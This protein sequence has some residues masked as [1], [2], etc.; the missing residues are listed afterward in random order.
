MF[1]ASVLD[2]KGLVSNPALMSFLHHDT[3]TDEQNGLQ[4]N[5]V[6]E[7]LNYNIIYVS[8]QTVF[9]TLEKAVTEL[10]DQLKRREHLENKLEYQKR[11]VNLVLLLIV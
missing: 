6:P 3:L 10:S 5:I 2:I 8:L 11:R 1:L 7:I 4:A 9:D